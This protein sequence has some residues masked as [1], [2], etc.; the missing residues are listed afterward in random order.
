MGVPSSRWLGL[1]RRALVA[2]VGVVVGALLAPSVAVIWLPGLCLLAALGWSLGRGWSAALAWVS[3]SLAI[4][5]SSWVLPQREPPRF[6]SERP[7][8]LVVDRQGSWRDRGDVF[9]SVATATLVRQRDVVDL[10]PLDVVLYWPGGQVPSSSRRLRLRGYLRPAA[11]FNN[12]TIEP[13]SGTW[14][15]SIES[16]RLAERLPEEAPLWASA[17]RSWFLGARDHLDAVLP[18]ASRGGTSGQSLAGA[19]LLGDSGRLPT[20]LSAALRRQGLA[21][22][23]AASGLHVGIVA[24]FCLLL[25]GAGPKSARTV[26]PALAVLVFVAILGLRPPLARAAGCLWCLVVVRSVGRLPPAGSVLGLSAAVLVVSDPGVVMDLGFQLSY[27]ATAGI[28]TLRAPLARVLRRLPGAARD[29]LAVSLAAQLATAPLVVARFANLP[30]LAPL[31]NLFFV[32][33]TAVVL[34]VAATWG[35][36]EAVVPSGLSPLLLDGLAKPFG[37]LEH[38]PPVSGVSLPV[39]MTVGAG[40][41][42]AA[43]FAIAICLGW[44]RIAVVVAAIGVVAAVAAGSGRAP[45]GAAE[46]VFLDVGQGDAI[47]LRDRRSVVL[48]DGGGLRRSDIAT[49]VLL[50]ALARLGV[51]RLDAALVSHGDHDH[52]GGVLELARWIPIREIWVGPTIDRT[53]CGGA[54][55]SERGAR[56]SVL[57]QGWRRRF[58]SF[59]LE[60][61]HAPVEAAT[62]NDESVVLLASAEGRRLLLTGDIQAGA[63]RA[64]VAHADP[65]AAEV[66][67]VAHHGSR[68]STAPPFLEAVRPKLAV[69]QAGR[70]NVYGHPSPAVIA[71]LAEHQTLVLRTDLDGQV[72][73]GWERGRPLRVRTHRLRLAGVDGPASLFLAEPP[74]RP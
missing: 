46:V 73:L 24:G 18:P 3:A 55:L 43:S 28:L 33:W 23:T 59:E 41:L 48:V 60:V 42:V 69:I 66:L 21:H 53:P 2:G 7:V 29:G 62:H 17:A 9:Q 5:C 20:A 70:R 57:V 68:T 64:L 71:R 6:E 19:L 51:R 54:L 63:E 74:R 39:Q 13:A 12:G 11:R 25:C 37:W 8:V 35:A 50:P 61:L 14:F 26:V 10:R 44:S 65:L 45:L 49:R 67:K 34:I 36:L 40:V 4:A 52:C 31:W 32:P 22:L 30:L 56:A 38:V 16:P 47:L 15:F 72:A 1:R 27:A 58:G